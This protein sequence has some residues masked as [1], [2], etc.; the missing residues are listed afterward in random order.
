M[1]YW[2]LVIILSTWDKVTMWIYVKIYVNICT[3][4]ND[5][6][7]GAFKTLV[8]L[9]E[10]NLSHNRYSIEFIINLK[11]SPL[12]SIL[13]SLILNLK[14]KYS[15]NYHWQTCFKLN[16]HIFWMS[17]PSINIPWIII[18]HCSLWWRRSFQAWEIGKQD[19]W[20][21]LCEYQCLQIIKILKM[22]KIWDVYLN[23][24]LKRGL[25]VTRIASA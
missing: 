6:I 3:P 2:W 20:P 9:Q 8:S 21:F 10:I 17:K 18:C 1:Y 7:S 23:F 12:N 24:T 25:F 4:N 16:S 5:L 15:L 13:F 14:K 22:I 19:C 11:I